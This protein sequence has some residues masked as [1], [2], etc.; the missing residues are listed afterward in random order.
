MT[1]ALSNV[2]AVEK[3]TSWIS[4]RAEISGPLTFTLIAGGRSNMTFAVSDGDL[5]LI[6][7]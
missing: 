1:E 2:I 3:V 7:I 5:S 4:E 6:H